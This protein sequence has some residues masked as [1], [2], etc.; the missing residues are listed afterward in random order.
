MCGRFTLFELPAVA[1][2]FGL[3][4]LLDDALAWARFNVAPSQ[5]I[6]VIT[7]EES[8]R[9]FV[10]QWPH[11][12][13]SFRPMA[14][15]SGRRSMGSAA[16]SRCR[17]GVKSGRLYGC[18]GLYTARPS[19]ADG[20]WVESCAIVTTGPNELMADI[21]NRMPVIPSRED[22]DAWLDPSVTDP[23]TVL[24]CLRPYPAEGMEA[25]PAADLVNSVRNDRPE[26][27]EQL[28]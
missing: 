2:R 23:A 11:T 22:E 27:I 19:A 12:A 20:E 15:M 9:C 5:Q 25:Y 18:A 7:Q 26:L 17:S 24:A 14:S 28:P 16:S 13:A 8:G 1:Q 21:H 4:L 10:G 6:P 3:Q